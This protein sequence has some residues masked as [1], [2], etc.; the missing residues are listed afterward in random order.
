MASKGNRGQQGWLW[1]PRSFAMGVVILVVWIHW[2]RRVLLYS[3]VSS[4]AVRLE[5]GGDYGG[6]ENSGYC[7]QC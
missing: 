7:P 1:T 5:E 6:R 4:E 3:R 2:V